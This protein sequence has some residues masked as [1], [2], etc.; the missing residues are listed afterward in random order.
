MNVVC[1][2]FANS[3]SRSAISVLERRELDGGRRRSGWTCSS[4]QRS[5]PHVHR[6]E[7]RRGLAG[8]DQHRDAERARTRPRS[9]RAPDR[10]AARARRCRRFTV[11]PKFLKI[12]SPRA[13]AST[14]ASRRSAARRRPAW[15]VD[16]VEIE[17]GEQHHAVRRRAARNDAERLLQ[18]SPGASAQVHEHAEVER[19][20]VADDL[21]VPLRRQVVQWWLWMSMTGYFARGTGCCGTTSVE[22][23]LYLR[24][25]RSWTLADATVGQSALRQ[26]PAGDEQGASTRGRIGKRR[27]QAVSRI[28]FRLRAPSHLSR[29]DG[30]LG[31]DDHSSSPAITGGIKRPTRRLR[32]GR[33]RNRAPPYLV[34]LRAGFCLPPVLPRARCALTAPF[35]PYS[36]SPALTGSASSLAACPPQRRAKRPKAGGIFSV[37]LSFGLP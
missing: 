1:G 22:R 5:L 24:M 32:T 28:L 36:P 11:S 16:V 19:V 8:V 4:S 30:E 29:R 17:V 9:G 2:C 31:G 21:R 23:G 25:P 14:S 13:P 35:H 6:L 15:L 37:P 12:L 34:L 10:R 7:E 33:P 3:R 18:L 20:H 26:A 27:S